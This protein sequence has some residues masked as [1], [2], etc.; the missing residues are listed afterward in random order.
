MGS[1]DHPVLSRI[2]CPYPSPLFYGANVA[3]VSFTEPYGL[4]LTLV[5][6]CISAQVAFITRIGQIL[7]SE[8][9]EIQLAVFQLVVIQLAVIQPLWFL[10]GVAQRI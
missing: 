4:S 6:Q 9:S 1:N 8:K 7:K 5:S 10:V 2:V 3:F